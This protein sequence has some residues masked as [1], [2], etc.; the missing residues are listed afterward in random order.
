[1]EH[2]LDGRVAGRQTRSI[3][4]DHVPRR[5]ALGFW[6]GIQESLGI[7]IF[8]G[9]EPQSFLPVHPLQEASGRA[10]E[11]TRP[12]VENDRSLDRRSGVGRL[13]RYH[14]WVLLGPANDLITEDDPDLTVLGVPLHRLEPG[15]FR[16]LRV[17]LLDVIL[18]FAH[19][20]QDAHDHERPHHQ[21]T[22]K[23]TLVS[24]HVEKCRV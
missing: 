9:E 17:H 18:E 23:E 1:M 15:L 7:G 6:D 24:G 19:E 13:H 10:A 3:G 16:G 11:G 12:L 2:E 8:E 20:E 21:D 5:V 22:E 14:A 4:F